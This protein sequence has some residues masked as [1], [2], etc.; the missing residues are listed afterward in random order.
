[1]G[2]VG[3]L[4]APCG[5]AS[6]AWQRA[7][8]SG[9]IQA[10][11]A[12]IVVLDVASGRLLAA[13]NPA[14]A[15]RT[16]AAPGSTLKPIVLYGLVS[17]GRWNPLN[18]IACNRQ[19]LV[20]GH[21]LA[22]SHPPAPPFDAREALTWS[23]NSYFAEVARSL[24]PGE[25]G[26]LL[27]PTGLLGATGLVHGEAVAEFREPVSVEDEQLALLGVQGVRVTPLELAAAYR[28]LALALAAHP[29][30]EAAQV[31]RAGLADSASFGMAGEANLGGV[32]VLGKTGTAD[33]GGSGRSHGWF[34]GLAPAQRPNV[35]IA[36]YVPVARGA[37]AA[38]V[39]GEI[40]SHAHLEQR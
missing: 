31:V 11:D 25:L 18:R 22:C 23:C 36:V 28:W 15:A 27:R 14:D 8:N 30:S 19:L 9:A 12:R 33:S 16:L 10:P 5:L 2:A 1:M 3:L 39:A 20:A 21:R 34:V 4:I 37:D 35:V 6:Q 38:H 24:R 17:A 40:L 29:D 7:V 13:H 26:D 32:P